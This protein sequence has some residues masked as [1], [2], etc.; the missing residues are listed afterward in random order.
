MRQNTLPE[1][2][3]GIIPPLFCNFKPDDSKL[4][5]IDNSETA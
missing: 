2:L 1:D 5:L 4:Q 3:R